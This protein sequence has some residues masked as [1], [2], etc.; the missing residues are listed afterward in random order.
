MAGD[1]SVS[2]CYLVEG[3]VSAVGILGLIGG[4]VAWWPPPLELVGLV[5]QM[6]KM[7]D[8]VFMRQILVKTLGSGLCPEPVMEAFRTC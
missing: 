3:I 6:Y 4:Y 8:G 1:G 7:L 5:S 2:R